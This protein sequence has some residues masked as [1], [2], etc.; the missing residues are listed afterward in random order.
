MKFVRGHHPGLS[1]D[2]ARIPRHMPRVPPDDDAADHP[3]AYTALR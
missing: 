2:L 3:D 1:Q